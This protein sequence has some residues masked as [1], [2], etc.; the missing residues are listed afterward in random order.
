MID[1]VSVIIC[2]HNGEKNLPETIRHLNRLAVD[3]SI[4]W[5]L[6]LIDNGSTDGTGDVGNKCWERPES[7]RIVKEPKRGL[8]NAR[9][10]GIREAR[11]EY[12][13]FIDDDNWVDPAWVNIIFE[14]FNTY[15]RVGVC[16]GI[17]EPVCEIEPPEWF[18]QFN[19]SYAVGT[20][21]DVSGDISDTRGYVW[22]A[23]ISIR[24]SAVERIID[25]GFG[26][27][28]SGRNGKK[29]LAGEDTELCYAMRLAGWRIWFDARL[30]LKH[31]IPRGRLRWEHLCKMRRGFGVARSILMMYQEL[32]VD[33]PLL[34]I[35]TPVHRLIINTWICHFKKRIKYLS[36]QSI[37]G[38]HDWLEFEYYRGYLETLLRMFFSYDHI[39]KNILAFKNKFNSSQGIQTYRVGS[40]LIIDDSATHYLCSGWSSPEYWVNKE[41]T[42]GVSYCH[43]DG[44]KSSILLPLDRIPK[45][46][47]VLDIHLIDVYL[48]DKKL[49][50]QRVSLYL[51]NKKVAY[52]I[53]CTRGPKKISVVV[54]P[55][56]ISGSLSLEI[57]FRCPDAYSPRRL[58]A[59]PDK[60]RLSICINSIQINECDIPGTGVN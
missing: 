44:K 29:L 42:S 27:Y 11:Y 37:V 2:S 34:R 12:I 43:M 23:G 24:K 46:G 57:M 1:G 50:K 39:Y 4:S 55:N 19:E 31:Y 36:G 58:E 40:K 14:I 54:D 26:S 6:I 52:Y 20:Q 18:S 60:R 10:R 17:N 51:N 59:V 15:P 22:G 45:K 32:L 9:L 48:L 47:F 3:P 56:I 33:D 53:Y 38:S 41:G 7:F 8:V 49:K 16:G 13:S 5:E 35:H 25:A 30:R 28:L 21:G